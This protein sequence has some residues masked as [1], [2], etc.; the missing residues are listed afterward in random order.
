CALQLALRQPLAPVGSVPH[1]HGVGVAGAHVVHLALLGLSY[2]CFQ[3]LQSVICPQDVQ[4]STR[5]TLWA[6]RTLDALCTCFTTGDGKFKHSGILCASVGH[7]CRG[8]GLSGCHL[9]N[10]DG[11]SL[12]RGSGFTLRSGRALGSLVAL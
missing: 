12:S 10:L 7:S 8:S 9:S 3:L 11:G 4:A 1:V 5:N 2:S 6:G